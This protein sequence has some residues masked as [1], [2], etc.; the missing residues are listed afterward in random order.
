MLFLTN[1]ERETKKINIAGHEIV[2]KTYLTVRENREVRDVLLKGIKFGL[3]EGEAKI[4]S[5]PPEVISQIENKN[6]EMA[7]VS[8]DGKTENILETILDFKADEFAELMKEITAITG[9]ITEKKNGI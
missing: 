3:D 1:M 7:I 8:I 9:G 2:L 5:I 6:I 4:D